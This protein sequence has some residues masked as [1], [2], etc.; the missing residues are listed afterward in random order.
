MKKLVA[1]VFLLSFFRL[2][3][4]FAQNV[5]DTVNIDSYEYPTKGTNNILTDFLMYSKIPKTYFVFKNKINYELKAEISDSFYCFTSVGLD[6]NDLNRIM[7]ASKYKVDLDLYLDYLFKSKSKNNTK[8][9]EDLF[10]ENEYSDTNS[11]ITVSKRFTLLAEFGKKYLLLGYGPDHYIL[12]KQ[13]KPKQY[14]AVSRQYVENRSIDQFVVFDSTFRLN[15]EQT[16]KFQEF[17]KLAMENNSGYVNFRVDNFENISSLMSTSKSP[18]IY[19]DSELMVLSPVKL[20][21]DTF[22]CFQSLR[23]LKDFDEEKNVTATRANKIYKQIIE[24]PKLF[25]KYLDSSLIWF[26]VDFLKD[27]ICKFANED[28]DPQIKRYGRFLRKGEILM[29]NEL[30]Y[31]YHIIRVVRDSEIKP[32]YIRCKL[33]IYDNKK[34]N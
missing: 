19:K 6:T 7:Q 32:A 20:I 18:F 16:H 9:Q 4:V 30:G 1:I 3:S 27:T 24:N 14:K 23:I 10:I 31:G 34:R 5:L 13:V 21:E 17:S 26:G 29:Q 28:Y 2:S 8:S 22:I 11:Y 25:D 12:A 15:I 33:E